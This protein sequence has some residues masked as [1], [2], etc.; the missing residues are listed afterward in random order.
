MPRALHNRSGIMRSMVSPKLWPQ[1]YSGG[2]TLY[3]PALRIMQSSNAISCATGLKP[4]S[5]RRARKAGHT[6]ARRLSRST[7]RRSGLSPRRDSIKARLHAVCVSAEPP[8]VDFWP[9]PFCVGHRDLFSVSQK[10]KITAPASGKALSAPRPA[11]QAGKKH[12]TLDP[13]FAARNRGRWT[14]SA[15]PEYRCTHKFSRKKRP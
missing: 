11:E 12:P 15:E 1:L 3:N 14:T 10:A 6:G 13:S 5:L 4:A 7:P 9:D 8:C 2:I